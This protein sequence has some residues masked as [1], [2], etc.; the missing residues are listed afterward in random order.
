LPRW[1]VTKK[2][3]MPRYEVIPHT[4]DIGLRVFGRDLKELF[5]NAAAGMMRFMIDDLSVF[6]C[7][8]EIE[9]KLSGL[10]QEELL[11]SWLG[12]LLYKLTVEHWLGGQFEIGS[13]DKEGDKY[14]LLARVKG[15]KIDYKKADIK[16]EIKAATYHNLAIKKNNGSWV[17]EI[18]FDV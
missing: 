7:R 11:V 4:A 12:E 18:I 9:I 8:E 13:L 17:V 14:S 6:D 10:S 15:Q 16:R 1:S 3:P 2:K 5:S